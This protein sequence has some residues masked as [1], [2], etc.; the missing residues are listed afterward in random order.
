MFCFISF[1]FA[2]YSSFDFLEILAVLINTLMIIVPR[3][4][5]QSLSL[6]LCIIGHAKR[7]FYAILG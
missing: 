4:I 7:H 1:S 2:R 5:V 6:S 3:A